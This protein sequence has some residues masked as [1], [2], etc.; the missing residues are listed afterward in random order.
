MGNFTPWDGEYEKEFYD[1]ELHDGEVVA[2]CWPNAGRI[3]ETRA[4]HREF[5]VKDVKGIRLSKMD[6]DE[7]IYE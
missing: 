2:E 3:C 7:V 5:E 6:W 1:V 4:P